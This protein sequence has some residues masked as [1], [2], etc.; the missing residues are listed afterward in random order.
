MEDFA[1][2]VANT[3]TGFANMCRQQIAQGRENNAKSMQNVDDKKM[4]LEEKLKQKIFEKKDS[5]LKNSF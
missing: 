2:T 5:S 1:F 3:L 4:E